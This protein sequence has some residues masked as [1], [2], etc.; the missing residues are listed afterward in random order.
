M[1]ALFVERASAAWR[2]GEATDD[3]AMDMGALC[4]E[5]G[6]CSVAVARCCAAAVGSGWGSSCRWSYGVTRWAVS[7]PP[8]RA[9][10]G[11]SAE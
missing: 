8:K 3:E 2:E 10:F 9:G 1:G 4:V 6:I 7:R 11:Q 5:R